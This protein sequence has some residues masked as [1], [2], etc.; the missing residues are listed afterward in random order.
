MAR[1]A[2]LHRGRQRIGHR[3]AR[4]RCRLLPLRLFPV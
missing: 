1:S 2:R 3:V 4:L